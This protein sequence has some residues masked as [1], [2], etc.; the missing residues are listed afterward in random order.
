MNSLFFEIT[1]VIGNL[2]FALSGVL[3][4]IR[5]DLDLLGIFILAFLTA[6]GG[7]VLR[8]LLVDRQPAILHSLMPLWL[9]C[10]VIGGVWLLKVNQGS[11]LEQQ[12]GFVV[13]DGVGLVAF[14]LT[15]SLIGVE[16]G[17]HF[18]GVI[19]LAFLTATG[20]GIIRDLLV[21]EVPLVLRSDFYGSIAL[22]LGAVIHLLYLVKW[23]NL[24]SLTI[25]FIMGLL[26][27]LLAYKRK[28][29]LPQ[30]G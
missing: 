30:L 26:L 28:W 6:N 24:V 15:G 27:R 17:L 13:S 21:N 4:G 9:T 8:D 29:R 19:I 12:W 1:S 25:V 7:G 22:V 5:K 20:G 23:L 10:T 18:F 16:Y 11:K 14:S 2:A 3:V